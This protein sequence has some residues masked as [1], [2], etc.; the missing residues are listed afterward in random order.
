MHLIVGLTCEKE[1]SY[2]VE[3][4]VVYKGDV[5]T[6]Q[7]VLFREQATIIKPA[8]MDTVAEEYNQVL[9]FMTRS[10]R[11]L[12]MMQGS[13]LT[14]ALAIEYTRYKDSLLL[15]GEKAVDVMLIGPPEDDVAVLLNKYSDVAR[16]EEMIKLCMFTTDEIRK[17][18]AK[19]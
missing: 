16:K 5:I 3:K 10:C 18:L 9:S 2:R 17:E 13:T 7:E 14:D 1:G 8:D 19:L 11:A 6:V 4:S 12:M 15:N